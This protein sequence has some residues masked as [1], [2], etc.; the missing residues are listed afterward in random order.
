M[1]TWDDQIQPEIWSAILNESEHFMSRWVY[2]LNFVNF[3]VQS[4][5]FAL[6]NVISIILGKGKLV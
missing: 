6:N 3:F 4:K 5:T 1:S 2:G